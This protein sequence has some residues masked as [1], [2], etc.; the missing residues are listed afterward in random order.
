MMPNRFVGFEEIKE[1]CNCRPP[2]LVSRC[3]SFLGSPLARGSLV[4]YRSLAGPTL[5]GPPEGPRIARLPRPRHI[6][7][8]SR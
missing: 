4:P 8:K 5:R 6:T 7:P 1:N 3:H 2:T